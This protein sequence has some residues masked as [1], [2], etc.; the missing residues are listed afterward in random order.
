MEM[1]R[2]LDELTTVPKMLM[3]YYRNNSANSIQ[4]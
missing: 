4:S 2:V 1:F 3:N